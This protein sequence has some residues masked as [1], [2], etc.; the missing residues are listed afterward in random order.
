MKCHRFAPQTLP[1]RNVQCGLF[2]APAIAHFQGGAE[3]Q[4]QLRKIAG[5]C[6]KTAGKLRCRDPD[7]TTD[8][9]HQTARRGDA[10]DWSMRPSPAAR[11]LTRCGSQQLFCG[12][13]NVFC[14]GTL[15]AR[16]QLRSRHTTHSLR[17]RRR[18]SW[19]SMIA[20][21]LALL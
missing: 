17:L 9:T 18:L 1:R 5:N 3:R 14:R 11:A 16:S 7:L 2:K 21:R 10:V 12:T 8:G 15:T 4:I 19:L 13:L 20:S 6:G